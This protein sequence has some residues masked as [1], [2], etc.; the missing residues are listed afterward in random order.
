MPNSKVSGSSPENAQYRLLP[1]AGLTGTHPVSGISYITQRPP[2]FRVIVPYPD[3][4][5]KV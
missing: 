2:L 4:P 3:G 1:S 5:V